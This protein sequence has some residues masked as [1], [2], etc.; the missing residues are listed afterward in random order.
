MMSAG[1]AR[2]TTISAMLNRQKK[3]ESTS[4]RAIAITDAV[5]KFV[6]VDMKTLSIV[7]GEGFLNLMKVI[8]SRYVVPSRNTVLEKNIVPMYHQTVGHVMSDM[9][10]AVRHAFTTDAW[11]SINMDSFIT[12]T[13]H[14]IEP[15]TFTLVSKVLDTKH[16][17]LSHTADNLATEMREVADKWGMK[18]PV[19]VTD[20]AANVVKG[21]EVGE[22]PHIGCFAHTMNIAVNKALQV[23]EVKSLIGKC[24]KLVSVFR[25]SYL[26][27]DKLHKAQA[28]LEMK[29]LQLIQDVETRWNSA[30]MMLRRLL[31]VYPAIYAT[32][33]D[34]SSYKHLLPSDSDRNHMQELIILWEPFEKSTV[35]VS[36][37]K[38]A[39]CSLI[40]PTLE[41][42]LSHHL[43]AK[44]TDSTFIQ[45]VKTAMHK[46]L[47]Q[48]YRKTETSQLLQMATI[49]DPRFKALTWVS[50]EERSDWYSS[51]SDAMLACE[52][53]QPQIKSE[54]NPTSPPVTVPEDPDTE[55]SVPKSPKR[56]KLEPVATPIPT[57]TPELEDNFFDCLF[58]CES[59][60][61]TPEVGKDI[62]VAREI[63]RY[64]SEMSPHQ[65]SDPLLWWAAHRASYPLLA[66]MALR[67]LNIPATSVPSERVFSTAGTILNKKRSK[68]SSDNADMLIFLHSNY[69]LNVDL[70]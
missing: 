9:N 15:T 53:I 27:T 37:E 65:S 32:L 33:Y 1:K 17:S 18:D 19:A 62:L 51:L 44:A 21:C 60:P 41:M 30:L 49:V 36:S 59:K 68:L 64:K 25:S 8:D 70:D 26:K 11:T 13:C 22:F 42:F 55:S 50:E 28:T 6:V 20:N 38:K 43:K 39:T 54:I 46:D 14:F 29:E 35:M 57:P 67:Y 48:R 45:R 63:Q 66:A 58:V 23:N 3:Y 69:K 56:V 2:Q 7:S 16:V 24:R 34:D 61:A 10:K 47:S 4:Q 40:L 52:P 5:A 31:K 12:T